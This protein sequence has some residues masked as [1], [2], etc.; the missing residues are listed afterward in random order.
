MS[1]QPEALRLA[2][3]LDDPV[4]STIYLA[5]YIA[6][7]LRRLHEVNQAMQ[8]ALQFIVDNSVDGGTFNKTARNAL[9]FKA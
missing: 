6:A 5:P 1:T 8:T 2:A 9:I 4:N 3:L 7:E